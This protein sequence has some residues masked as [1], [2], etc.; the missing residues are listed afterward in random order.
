MS[1]FK[2]NAFFVNRLLII[3]QGFSDIFFNPNGNTKMDSQYPGY[4][5]L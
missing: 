1:G 4:S 2:V 5:L 3:K